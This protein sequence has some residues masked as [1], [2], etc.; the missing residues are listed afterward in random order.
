VEFIAGIFELVFG[1]LEIVFQSIIAIFGALAGIL[2]TTDCPE[3]RRYQRRCLIALLAGVTSI[4]LCFALG[5]YVPF[6]VSMGMFV[7]GV[8]FLYVAGYLGN[9]VES[10]VSKKKQVV[11]EGD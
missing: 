6:V 8:L 7:V 9:R 2:R 10:M 1:L 4:G 3:I 5:R 11:R